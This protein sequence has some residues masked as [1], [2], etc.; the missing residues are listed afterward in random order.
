MGKKEVTTS[1]VV[2][3]ARDLVT[4]DIDGEIVMMSV[5]NGKYYGMDTI[6]TDIWQ[7]MENPVKISDLIDTLV[8]KYDVDKSTCKSD[9]LLFLKDLNEDGIIRIS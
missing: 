4:S 8:E 3:Q 1:D 6:G 5:E 9:V 7:M 2:C